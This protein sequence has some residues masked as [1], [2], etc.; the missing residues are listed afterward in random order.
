[1][2]SPRADA[3]TCRSPQG[4]DLPVPPAGALVGVNTTLHKLRHYSATELIRAGVDVRTVAGRLGHADGGTTLAYYAAW[5]READQRASR[6]LMRQLPLPAPPRVVAAPARR[7]RPRSPYRVMA[8]ELRTAIQTGALPSGTTLPTVEQ[9]GARY[10]VH[11]T[12]AHRAIALLAHEHLI[13]VS[14][15]RRAIVNRVS[16]EVHHA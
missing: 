9:L 12:T 6:I 4:P 7:V 11:S 8:T 5:V 13:T 1:V 2:F 10:H 14:R 16:E 15:G 3:R